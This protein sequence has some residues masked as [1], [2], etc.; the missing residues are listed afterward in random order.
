M[1]NSLASDIHRGLELERGLRCGNGST[2]G[3]TRYL[4]EEPCDCPSMHA[5]EGER[6]RASDW[7][8]VKAERSKR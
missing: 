2:C 8:A 7:R 1:L 3:S 5:T 4:R 6:I